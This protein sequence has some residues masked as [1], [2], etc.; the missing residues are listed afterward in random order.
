MINKIRNWIR[1]FLWLGDTFIGVDAGYNDPSCI[2]VISRKHNAVRII[3]EQFPTRGELDK[4][5]ERL[6]I[7]YGVDRNRI[8][9][10]YPLY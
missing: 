1:N 4:T 8:A 10:D 2:V 3:E 9:R 5:V 6:R 7:A